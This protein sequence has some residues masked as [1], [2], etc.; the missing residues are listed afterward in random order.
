MATSSIHVDLGDEVP[1]VDWT[2]TFDWVKEMMGLSGWL[3]G[4]TTMSGPNRFT[5]AEA[6]QQEGFQGRIVPGNLGMMAMAMAVHRWLPAATIRKLDCVFR[7][8]LA[9]GQKVTASGVVTDKREED[10]KILL[11]LDLYLVRE[12]GQ[13][14]QGGTAI[15]VL[16]PGQ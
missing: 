5:N 4:R 11:E 6:A 3:S 12:D 14:P 9:Q 2:P 8:P 16:S 1:A 13:R 7:Q 10:G 15:V